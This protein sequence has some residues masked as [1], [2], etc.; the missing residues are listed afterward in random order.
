LRVVALPMRDEGGELI[1][2]VRLS[3]MLDDAE[4]D[5]QHTRRRL[6]ILSMLF[7]A[8]SLCAGLILGQL[9]LRRPLAS[10]NRT[11]R[12]IDASSESK[13]LPTERL[14]EVGE[15]ARAFA[16]QLNDL[17]EAQERA[18]RQ[19]QTHRQLLRALQHADKLAT[20]GQMVAQVAHEVGTPLQIIEGRAAALAESSDDPLT[21]K[22]AAQ[23]LTQS[24]RLTRLIQQL[25]HRARR[26]GAERTSV[27]PAHVVRQVVELIEV[28]SKRRGVS[29]AMELRS[30]PAII[31]SVDQVEQVTLNLLTNALRAT[32]QGGH[33]TV[34]VYAE[35][36][37]ERAGCAI[38][39]EDTGS[40][41]DDELAERVFEPFF[42][43]AASTGGLGL[44]LVIVREILLAHEGHVVLSN[45]SGG[46]CRAWTW[47]PAPETLHDDATTQGARG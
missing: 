13:A 44:G 35:R 27:E 26:A 1:G 12:S 8:I 10:M 36:H 45:R 25:L 14:D 5:L 22:H 24:E 21:R 19:E 4:E 18:R 39:V 46:G 41:L 6:A 16:K 43:T 11:L 7:A 2:V 30:C 37:E 15:L 29:V 28:E 17:R 40:G 31:A 20:I 34:S 42:T 47:W 38:V 32:P 3:R 9:L 23:I 33:I